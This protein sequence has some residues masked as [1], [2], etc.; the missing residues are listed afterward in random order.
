MSSNQVQS[1]SALRLS[2]GE[3]N[4]AIPTDA[5]LPLTDSRVE[6][7]EVEFLSWLTEAKVQD[8]VAATAAGLINF[9]TLGSFLSDLVKCL[10]F[11]PAACLFKADSPMLPMSISFRHSLRHALLLLLTDVNHCAY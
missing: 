4:K 5:D 8:F 2:R 3:T 6:E 10:C 11:A 9:C 1:I 7:A